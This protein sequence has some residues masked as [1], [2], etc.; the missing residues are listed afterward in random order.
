M[1]GNE[2]LMRGGWLL[3]PC[4][5]AG[6]GSSERVA[7]VTEPRAAAPEPEAEPEPVVAAP[8]PPDVDDQVELDETSCVVR[9]RAGTVSAEC[10]AGSLSCAE[11]ARADLTD[12]PGEEVVARCDEPGSPPGGR[13]LV[14]ANG[15]TLQWVLALDRVA[16]R[17]RAAW[18]CAS[19]HSRTAAQ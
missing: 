4:M 15:D 8:A 10:T 12:A 14:V 2:V 5:L 9:T 6:C 7:P 17:C 1:S 18:T 13:A 3:I 11:I 16:V 19:R